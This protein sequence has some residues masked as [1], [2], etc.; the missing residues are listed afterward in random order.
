M[1]FEQNIQ[2]KHKLILLSCGDS[3]TIVLV[4]IKNKNILTTN[5]H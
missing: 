3:S 2:V 1:S 5:L 4:V